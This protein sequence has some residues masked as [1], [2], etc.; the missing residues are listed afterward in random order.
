MEVFGRINGL[1]GILFVAILLE[2]SFG[3]VFAGEGDMAGF[4][5]KVLGAGE[6]EE[7]KGLQITPDIE[8]LIEAAYYQY[9]EGNLI[10]TKMAFNE[11]IQK[12]V[13]A[14]GSFNI[15]NF[16][17]IL[18]KGEEL[19]FKLIKKEGSEA[20]FIVKVKEGRAV[21]ETVEDIG[22]FIF[23]QDAFFQTMLYIFDPR[24]FTAV[25]VPNKDDKISYGGKV[26][27]YF[28]GDKGKLKLKKY[29]LF[30]F[31]WGVIDPNI[32]N[33][34]VITA[35]NSLI[36]NGKLEVLLSNKYFYDFEPDEL[37]RKSFLGKAISV[38]NEYN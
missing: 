17:D 23:N 33:G 32:K 22:Q 19:Q 34:V 38:I 7:Y 25:V 21:Y 1:L 3:F 35:V 8:R 18:P 2:A 11:L 15:D 26:Y 24:A 31:D 20:G 36:K 28:R 37:E 4:G 14:G 16:I 30:W 10:E 27:Y 13:S 29:S 6:I 12:R 9:A 5:F